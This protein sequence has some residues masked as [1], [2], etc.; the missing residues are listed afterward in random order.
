MILH[1]SRKDLNTLVEFK[2]CYS[3]EPDYLKCERNSTR[4]SFFT[5]IRKESRRVCRVQAL[6]F[7]NRKN[8]NT[9]MF[10]SIN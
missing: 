6:L 5:E 4:D 1:C 7:F 9:E 8:V 10:P 3:S 2:H